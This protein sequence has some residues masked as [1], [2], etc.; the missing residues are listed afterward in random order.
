MH[1]RFCLLLLQ[2]NYRSTYTAQYNAPGSK[3]ENYCL[4]FCSITGFG[5]F[6]LLEGCFSS[7]EK[8]A[9]KSNRFELLLQEFSPGRYHPSP[10]FAFP[11][12]PRGKERMNERKK[13][14][15]KES[16]GLLSD[17]QACRLAPGTLI[18]MAHSLFCQHRLG[19]PGPGLALLIVFKSPS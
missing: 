7:L 11:R 5:G 2:G 16:R 14:P 15:Q 1:T 19:K 12:S 9:L 10:F 4:D 6:F 13:N 3:L 18:G 17:S 8:S